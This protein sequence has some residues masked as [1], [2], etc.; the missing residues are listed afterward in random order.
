M[1][2]K[3]FWVERPDGSRTLHD[4]PSDMGLSLMEALKA[5]DYPIEAT[6]GGIALCATCRIEWIEGKAPAPGDAELDMLDTLPDAGTGSRLSCQ[7]RLSDISDGCAFRVQALEL[8]P[9]ADSNN[10]YL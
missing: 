6:C 10:L 7:L 3:Q 1:A 9:N 8:N 5:L 2:D 4:V